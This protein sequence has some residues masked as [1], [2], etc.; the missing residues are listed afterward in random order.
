[1]GGNKVTNIAAGA[2][3]AASKEAVSGA[4]LFATNQAV[5]SVSSVAGKLGSTTAA[6]MGGTSSYDAATGT[7]TT[8]LDLEG[9][10]Y[11]SVNDALDAVVVMLSKATKTTVSAGDN[12]VV[13]AVTNPDG[14][15]DYQVATAKDLT[16]D[17][18]T[19]GGAVLNTSGLKVSDGTNSTSFGAGGMIITGG[20]SV[21]VAGIDAGAKKITN[22]AAGTAA[23]DAANVGQL[24]QVQ[25]AAQAHSD[26][27]GVTTA[28]ALGGGAAYDAASGKVSAPSY[29]TST[30]TYSNVGDALAAA[31]AQT[32]ALGNSVAAGMGGGSTY[33]AATGKVDTKLDVGGTSY[34]NVNDA[35]NAV[36]NTASAG[37]NVSVNGANSTK[38]A[39]GATVNMANTD[40]NVV[41]TKPAGSTEI[42]F[43]LAKNLK[44]EGLTVGAGTATTSI[45][46]MGV[47][48]AGGP[49]MT[50]TGINAGGLALTNVK[51]GSADTD[52]VN[53]AQLRASSATGLAA[54][55]AYTDEQIAGVRADMWDMTRAARAGTASAMASATLPQAFVPGGGMT[56]IGVSHY[57]GEQ[58]VAAGMSLMTP[59]GK[60]VIKVSGSGNTGGEW[61][62]SIG[63]GFAW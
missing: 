37:W 17:S 14:S 11:N 12:M 49:S 55:K 53:V 5:A 23:T 2:V 39:P 9:T 47:T 30:G 20:P 8:A 27:L 35:I 59:D 57:Q 22:V 50:T 10:T 51:A 38:V 43:N 45:N 54:A 18:V 4:Q 44:V 29:M 41:I 42:N 31:N 63:A 46:G 15:M 61:G 19:A 32:N 24:Q 36:N 26:Q 6:G 13:T 56:T 34:N 7:L 40:G 48:I 28:A 16:V 58:A 52:G 60:K 21:T 1:M 3:T 25:Q 33:N 62:I